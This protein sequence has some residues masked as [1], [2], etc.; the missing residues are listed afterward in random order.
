M[1]SLQIIK[2]RWIQD[3]EHA[4][5]QCAC[6]SRLQTTVDQYEVHEPLNQ[7]LR[8]DQLNQLRRIYLSWIITCHKTTDV[9]IIRVGEI[10]LLHSATV[11][12]VQET[13]RCLR[14]W[15]TF[16]VF[17]A[18]RC[19]RW[20]FYTMNS[21]LQQKLHVWFCAK[22]AGRVLRLLPEKWQTSRCFLY[23]VYSSL[24]LFGSEI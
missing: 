22:S 19:S 2:M 23:W 13:S 8:P 12:T 3:G 1:R 4:T 17:G 15:G 20:H 5:C 21:W 16:S 7:A 18:A 9:E 10:N 6:A 14:L 24:P 11:C